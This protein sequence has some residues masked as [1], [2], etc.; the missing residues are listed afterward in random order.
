MD[1]KENV[2]QP[3]SPKKIG[4]FYFG[5]L[6]ILFTF[7]AKFTQLVFHKDQF[8]PFLPILSLS[9]PWGML[10]GF[11]FGKSLSKPRRAYIPILLGLFMGL[12]TL[13]MIGFLVFIYYYGKLVV[14]FYQSSNA[15]GE[16][17]LLKFTFLAIFYLVGIWV[18]PL[19]AIAALHFN[20]LFWPKFK[21]FNLKTIK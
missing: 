19:T 1:L 12:L 17:L 15:H 18:L 5:I 11:L 16:Y 6:A 3:L 4:A 14:Y 7:S 20:K 10:L 21:A 9:F 2:I 8:I 13:L